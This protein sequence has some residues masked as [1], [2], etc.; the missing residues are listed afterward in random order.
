MPF[1]VCL[2]LIIS[3]RLCHQG[4][5]IN[6]SAVRH[7]IMCHLQGLHQHNSINNMLCRR[8]LRFSSSNI[9]M[10]LRLQHRTIHL[11]HHHCNNMLLNNKYDNLLLRFM[12]DPRMEFR[13]SRKNQR[14]IL[15][16]FPVLISLLDPKMAKLF[17]FTIPR[18][19]CITMKHDHLL[20][21]IH[22][23]SLTMMAMLLHS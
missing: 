15:L 7:Y 20:P 10:H 8:R 6:L 22:A 21:Q 16:K 9:S 5:H 1:I 4:L 13:S 23:L 3:N 11:L 17:Q 14:L 2:L 12:D 19:P 18:K